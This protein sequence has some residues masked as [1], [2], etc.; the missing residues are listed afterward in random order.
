MHGNLES[1]IMAD[2][3]DVVEKTIAEDLVVTKYKMAGEIVNSEFPSR[4]EFVL[5]CITR[6]A[7][8]NCWLS[9]KQDVLPIWS[10]RRFS[11]KTTLCCKK[12]SLYLCSF[13]YHYR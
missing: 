8:N 4:E 11:A 3:K 1:E 10:Y 9:F 6:F 13:I 2:E 5:L 12:T 7:R